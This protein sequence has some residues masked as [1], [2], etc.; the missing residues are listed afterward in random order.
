MKLYSS[1]D[2]WGRCE[3]NCLAIGIIF[4]HGGLNWHSHS[5]GDIT[6]EGFVEPFQTKK[7]VL[8]SRYPL[9]TLTS[10]WA[11]D[12]NIL[13]DFNGELLEYLEDPITGIER[14]LRFNNIWAENREKLDDI[15][16]VRYENLKIDTF[17]A[18]SGVLDFMGIV[19]NEKYIKEAIEFSSFENMKRIQMS[20]DFSNIKARRSRFFKV[21]NPSNPEAHHVRRGK[22]GGYR[23]YLNPEDAVRFEARI[24]KEMNSWY[25]YSEPPNQNL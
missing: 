13:N 4:N 2:F 18:L 6:Y 23:D 5:A 22:V 9:D 19:A 17:A 8:I 20:K 21:G 1:Y 11:F 3:S 16:L 12:A 24:S 7:T 14:C 25:G 10:N 15:S